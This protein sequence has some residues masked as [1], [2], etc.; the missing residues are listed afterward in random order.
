MD[1]LLIDDHALVVSGIA[2]LLRES[3]HTV[4]TARDLAGGRAALAAGSF[5]LLLLDIN[6]G[7]ESGLDLLEFDKER[8]PPRIVLL[9]GVTE[10]ETIFRGFAIGAFGFIP[11]SVEP[12]ELVTALADMAMRPYLKESGWVWDTQ[13]HE[14]QDAYTHFPRETVLTPKERQVFMLMREGKLDKQIADDMGLSIHTVRVHIR[15]IKRKRG[16]NRRFEQQF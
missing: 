1:I 8:L 12:A 3:G 10:Q 14:A 15:A 4:A 2:S 6:L 13:R 7:G 16:H 5:D 11:K 9:S